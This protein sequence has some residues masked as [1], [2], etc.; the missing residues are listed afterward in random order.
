MRQDESSKSFIENN[1]ERRAFM[2]KILRFDQ[3]QIVALAS[4]LSN[5]SAI[6]SAA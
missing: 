1:G 5:H 6:I 4:G 3:G 2:D